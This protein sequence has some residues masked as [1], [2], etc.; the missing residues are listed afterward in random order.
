LRH[1]SPAPDN[2]PTQDAI[3]A[4]A[5]Q[6]PGPLPQQ[7]QAQNASQNAGGHHNQAADTSLEDNEEEMQTAHSE[8]QLNPSSV[9]ICSVL[10]LDHHCS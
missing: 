2:G 8:L 7:S 10:T 3:L 1:A 4:Q 6:Q 5:A 9:H